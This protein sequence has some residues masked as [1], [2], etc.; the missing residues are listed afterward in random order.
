[1]LSLIGLGVLLTS[2]V[3]NWIVGPTLAVVLVVVY[4][5]LCRRVAA[6]RVGR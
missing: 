5:S 3:L 1:V 6:R 2:V 4:T